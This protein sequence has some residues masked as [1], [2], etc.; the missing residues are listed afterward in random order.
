MIFESPFPKIDIPSQ[1]LLDCVFQNVAQHPDRTA[2]IE[3]PTGRTST[4]RELVDGIQRTAAALAARGLS[5]GDVCAIYSRNV[6]EYIIAFYA[7]VATGGTVTTVNPLYTISELTHQLRDSGAR[8]LIAGSDELETATQSAKQTKLDEI[9]VFGDGAGATPFAE[10]AAYPGAEVAPRIDPADDVAAL[11]YSSGTTGLPKGVM[12]TH[13]NLVANILQIDTVEQIQSSEVLIAT[14]PFYHIYGMVVVMSVGLRAGA[15]LVT[16]PHFRV[17]GFLETIERH[18]VTTAY[19]VPP[20]VRTLAKHALVERY[21]ISSLTDVVSSAAQLPYSIAKACSQRN[22]CNVRQAYGL[23]EASPLTH[24]T[25]RNSPRSDSS[26][27]AV[28][29]NTEFRVVDVGSRKDV[30]V[31]E[32]GEVWVRGPQVMKGYLDNPEATRSMIDDDRWLHTGDIGYTDRD[33]FLFV[34]DRAKELIKFRALQYDEQDLFLEM[35]EDIGVRRQAANQV[36]FQALLLDNVRESIVA[37]NSRNEITFWNKGAEVLFGYAAEEALSKKAEDLIIPTGADS[38]SQ[39]RDELERVRNTDRWTGQ[40]LRR[41]AD[42]TLLWADI[43]VSRILDNEGNLSGLVAIHRDITEDRRQ[44]EI[45]RESGERMRNLA[46]S[47]MEVREQERTL[48]SRELHDELGQA[49]TRLNIDLTWLT[50]RLPKQLKTKRA[51]SIVPLVQRTIETVQHLAYQLR[52]PILDDLGLEAAIEWQ[53]QE[54]IE[55][56]GGKCNLDLHIEKLKSNLLR[57]TAVFRIVQ[58]ALTNIA[59]HARAGSI[60]LR[61]RIS[62]HGLEVEIADDGV[63][64]PDEKLASGQSLGLI[65]MRERAAALGGHVDFSRRL[66]TG[67]I[68]TV[69]MPLQLNSSREAR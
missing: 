10:L 14:V 57:D 50:E 21:D 58:E 69:R 39:W 64:L 61:A 51:R 31:G 68:I 42:G 62:D 49:L 12:L 48:I 17:Q 35:M 5:K 18:R 38:F 52:P 7:I 67:T 23:T 22:H 28:V 33:G 15:T 43:S 29:S 65:G 24:M 66:P 59:R 36:N 16:L 55:W 9:F 37:T 25:S 45:I 47:L 63:G 26:V 1:T 46:A 27:G 6:P 20:L 2:V 13:R 3:G 8:Y 53:A 11:P 60:D 32:L 56:H 4:Y 19:I 44:Q 41:R 54:F 34:V 30:N 40:A